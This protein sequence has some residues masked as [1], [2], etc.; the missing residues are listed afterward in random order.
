MTTV[1]PSAVPP[2]PVTE[3]DGRGPTVFVVTPAYPWPPTDGGRIGLAYRIR[4]LARLGAR[5]R[6]YCVAK[7]TEMP[8]T[9]PITEWCD[10]VT[11]VPRM[12]ALRAAF[13][14]PVEPYQAT[15]RLVSMLFERL[16]EDCRSLKPDVVQL[17]HSYMAAYAHAVPAGVPVVLG[18]HNVEAAALAARAR[19]VGVS[20][21]AA[22]YWLEAARMRRYERRVF[23]DNRIGAFVFVSSEELRAVS[24]QHP[25]V[26][27]R[28][29][30]LPPGT[31]LPP[32]PAKGKRPGESLVFVGSLWYDPNIEGLR[33]FLN[34]VWPHVCRERPTATLVVAGRGAS[35]ALA[36][37]LCATPGVEFL[38]EVSDVRAAYDRARGVVLPVRLGAGVKVKSIEALGQGVPCIGTRHAFSG[39]GIDVDRFAACTDDPRA[40]ATAAIAALDGDPTLHDRAMAARALVEREFTWEAIGRRHLE[41]LRAATE[42]RA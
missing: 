35:P 30:F 40:F 5:I 11:V 14:R 31:E 36:A 15:S 16:R 22:G 38:G 39:L 26:G 24:A 17:E 41:V 10:A 2:Q 34:E 9:S 18:I 4:E 7:P 29:H 3:P 20:P 13:T 27:D 33:W 12:P 1:E 21:A 19:S 6:L 23:A 8:A 37:E 28:G 25:R 42:T 32:L